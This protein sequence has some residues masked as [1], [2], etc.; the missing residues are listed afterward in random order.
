L[1]KIAYAA[2]IAAPL[3]AARS[4]CFGV[5]EHDVPASPEMLHMIN[6]AI[7]T[8]R[9]WLQRRGHLPPVQDYNAVGR[10]HLVEAHALH[11]ATLRTGCPT[12][13]GIPRAVLAG[14]LTKWRT[15][16]RAAPAHRSDR[17]DGK[18]VKREIRCRITAPCRRPGC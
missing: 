1:P 3:K 18:G 17:R 15:T 6:R 2:A 16:S 11:E 5:H 10:G 8:L 4:A 13:R 9:G 12:I 7:A 14:A